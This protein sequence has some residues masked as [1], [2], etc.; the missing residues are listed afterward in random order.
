MMCPVSVANEMSGLKG[1]VEVVSHPNW[2]LEMTARIYKD[3]TRQRIVSRP[4]R[5][6][7]LLGRVQISVCVGS[8]TAPC[9]ACRTHIRNEAIYLS[10]RQRLLHCFQ[11]IG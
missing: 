10:R 3:A 11:K 9:L 4:N 8:R 7:L 1:R 6:P 2:R 5:T